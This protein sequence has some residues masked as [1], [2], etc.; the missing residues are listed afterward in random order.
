MKT[1]QRLIY[2]LASCPMSMG[3]DMKFVVHAYHE[4]SIAVYNSQE[5]PGCHKPEVVN[6]PVGADM[7]VLD[8]SKEEDKKLFEQINF[9]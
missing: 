4:Y 1:E 6:I 8:L 2:D 5:T 3:L 9:N 7:K